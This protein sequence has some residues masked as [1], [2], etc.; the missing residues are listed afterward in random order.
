MMTY[1]PKQDFYKCPECGVEV[2]P[3]DPIRSER[4][5]VQNFMDQMGPTHHTV[6]P[7][8]AGE[9]TPGGSHSS[10]SKRKAERMKRPSTTTLYN[11][12]YVE[13]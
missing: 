2:W 8:P 7:L 4:T 1:N 13:N 9:P 5:A 11:R 3:V 12:L 10:K 6:T